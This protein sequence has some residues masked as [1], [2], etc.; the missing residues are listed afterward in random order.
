MRASRSIATMVAS[1][2]IATGALV[3]LP[4]S[5]AAD[6]GATV[7]SSEIAAALG[8]TDASNGGLVQEPVPSTTDADSA[9]IVRRENTTIEAP[10]DPED[11]VSLQGDGAPSVTIDLPNADASKDAVR[12]KDGTVAY[13]GTDGSAQAV[14]PTDGGVQMLTTIANADAPTRYDY[15]V[16]VPD[17]GRVELLPDNAGAVVNDGNGNPVVVVPAVWAKDANGTAVPTHFETDGKTLTQVVNH[18]SGNYAYPVVADPFW[19]APIV[20]WKIVRC[21]FGAYIGWISS[22]GWKWYQRAVM[23]IGG[24][25]LGI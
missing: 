12:L 11:G 2:V 21:G 4:S 19:L 25:I 8:S 20:V 18:T 7:T 5:A 15:K 16:G 3:A 1:A 6:T 23:L 17:G 24:C 22:A 9:A 14:I 10:K 13:P